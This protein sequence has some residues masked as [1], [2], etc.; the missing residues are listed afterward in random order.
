MVRR[1]KRVSFEEAV[2]YLEPGADELSFKDAIEEFIA[3]RKLR[4]LAPQTIKYYQ[5][6]M[7]YLL[8]Y[9]KRL[10]IE[11][12]KPFQVQSN[13][14]KKIITYLM[15]KGNAITGIN[16]Y[17]RAWR[18]FFNFLEQENYLVENPFEKVKS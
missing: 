6:G 4:N 17:I 8:I 16:T 10:D 12:E 9:L 3:D 1:T 15:E 14:I 11:R 5:E 7:K 13:D 2:F 18:T